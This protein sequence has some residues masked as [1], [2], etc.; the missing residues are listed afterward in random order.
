MLNSSQNAL[1][2]RKVSTPKTPK[3]AKLPPRRQSNQ[4]QRRDSK[5]AP[6]QSELVDNIDDLQHE[7]RKRAAKGLVTKFIDS[8]KQAVHEGKF[9]LPPGQTADAYGNQLGLAVEYA[10]FLNFWVP[11]AEPSPL[12]GEKLRTIIHN[13]KQNP[14]LRDSLLSGALAPN[15]LTTMSSDDMMRKD[16]KEEKA[17]LLKQA[18]KQHT[19]VH[20]EGPRIR[21]TH[22]G[23]EIVGEDQQATGT[24]ES[25]YAGATVRPRRES[26]ADDNDVGPD[27]RTP[28]SPMDMD[29]P[30]RPLVVDTRAQPADRKFSGNFDIDNAWSSVDTPSHP[31]YHH[32]ASPTGGPHDAPSP[33]GP[34]NADPEIARLL[35]D[36]DDDDEPYSPKEYT[37]DGTVWRGTLSM[38]MVAEFRGAAQHVAGADLSA[39]HP[40]SSMMPPVLTI[41]GRIAVEKAS[42]YL[43]GLQWSKTTDVTVVAVAPSEH[44]TPDDRA[45]FNKLFEYFVSRQRYG[46]VNKS[47]VALVRDTYV[48][49]LEA[50]AAKKPEFIELLEN[51]TL[52]D[53]RPARLL[54]VTYVVKSRPDN[55]PPSNQTTPREPKLA[56]SPVAH[57]GGPGQF[58]SPVAAQEGFSGP[59]PQPLR[60]GWEAARHVLGPLADAPAVVQLLQMAPDTLESSFVH[61][62]IPLETRPELREDLGALITALQGSM[63]GVA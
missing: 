55:L 44:A 48:V 46:V 28:H 51:C 5:G 62:K 22:K 16:Q 43:C 2:H 32:Q 10:L 7:S 12:Y 26:E 14:A 1:K 19:L 21:R 11:K 31:K 38:P 52:G 53:D 29:H 39:V 50:G 59:P 40:W 60:Q 37:E 30:A 41:E 8:T 25:I 17:H 18:E 36:H 61:I 49:P 47:P 58:M 23:E 9:T 24:N 3:D 15:T 27:A 33:T 56:N 42:E 13:V 35:H 6:F 4:P 20:E 34:T 63:G 45:Q 57:H 54:L